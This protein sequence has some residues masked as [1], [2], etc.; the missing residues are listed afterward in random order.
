MFVQDGGQLR[1]DIRSFLALVL[2]LRRGLRSV[3]SVVA[4][5]RLTQ[6]CYYILQNV[7][8]TTRKLVSIVVIYSQAVLYACKSVHI[9]T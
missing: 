2:A 8:F 1:C 5:C 7:L 4:G 9:I 3:D 6:V